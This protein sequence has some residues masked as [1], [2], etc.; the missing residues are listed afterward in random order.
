MDVPEHY[1][2]KI[3]RTYK[4]QLD[5]K[6]VQLDIVDDSYNIKRTNKIFST[7]FEIIENKFFIN[8]PLK[9]IVDGSKEDIEGLIGLTKTL[10]DFDKTMMPGTGES[11]S[12][13]VIKNCIEK[14][15]KNSN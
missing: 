11:L 9:S 8:I 3:K 13:V 15:L 2:Q 14:Q 4:G 6:Y 7:E 10:K 1:L 12:S 5:F